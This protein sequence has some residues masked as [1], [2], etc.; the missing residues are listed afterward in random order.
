MEIIYFYTYYNIIKHA[1]VQNA[2]IQNVHTKYE[3]YQIL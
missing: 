3:I 2:N 1:N